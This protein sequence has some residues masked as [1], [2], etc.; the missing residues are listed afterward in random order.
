MSRARVP[1][2]SDWNTYHS[3]TVVRPFLVDGCSHRA[4]QA[5][6]GRAAH[7]RSKSRTCS[8]R[9]R[10]P[11]SAHMVSQ[12]SG[13]GWCFT[14]SCSRQVK[15]AA[16]PFVRGQ[17]VCEIALVSQPGPLFSLALPQLLVC[18]FTHAPTWD[19]RVGQQAG[20]HASPGQ[21][22][23]GPKGTCWPSTG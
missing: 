3:G 20:R 5:G 4:Y 2:E 16:V 22:P 18:C 9:F 17:I 6:R 15:V 14:R 1:W 8:G 7:T 23:L 19:V 13:W 11:A 21:P 12:V 10:G